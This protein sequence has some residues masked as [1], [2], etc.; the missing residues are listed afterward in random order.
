MKLTDSLRS[1]YSYDVSSVKVDA[2]K[3]IIVYPGLPTGRTWND[4]LYLYPLP[5]DQITLVNYTQNQ[6]W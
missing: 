1:Q 5:T 4:K 6:G 3:Y 2:N